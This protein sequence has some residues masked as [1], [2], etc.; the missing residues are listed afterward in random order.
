[1]TIVPSGDSCLGDWTPFA[2]PSLSPVSS[3]R[4]DN[5]NFNWVPENVVMEGVDVTLN[6]VPSCSSTT[7]PTSKKS[8]IEGSY[9]PTYLCDR[10]EA[11]LSSPK[12]K[13]FTVIKNKHVKNARLFHNIEITPIGPI[14]GHSIDYD[15][16]EKSSIGI[17]RAL[18]YF[19]NNL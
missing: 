19:C 6:R 18:D 7:K 8:R 16:S 3:P 17:K 12:K 11:V 15:E 10:F 2:S 14:F 5:N 13:K 4:D 9:T 1:M